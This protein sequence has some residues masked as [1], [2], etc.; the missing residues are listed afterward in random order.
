MK[1]FE[2]FKSLKNFC[3]YSGLSSAKIARANFMNKFTKR[4]A[5]KYLSKDKE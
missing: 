1:D 4:A 3:L 5:P 2:S